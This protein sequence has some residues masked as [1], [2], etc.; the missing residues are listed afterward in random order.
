[1]KDH[2]SWVVLALLALAFFW[3]I[4]YLLEFRETVFF[5]GLVLDEANYDA[6][7]RDIAAGNIL[8]DG[9]FTSNPLAPYLI[10]LVYAVVGRDLWWLRVV[11]AGV[12]TATCYFTFRIAL[13]LFGRRSA[14]V[15]L[16]LAALYGPMIFLAGNLV[17]TVWVLAFAS[18]ALMQLTHPQPRTW[19]HVA[20][21]AAFGLATLGRPNLV[22]MLPFLPAVA[23]LRT[24]NLSLRTVARPT[25]LWAAGLA[26]VLGPVGV[27][28]AL[29]GGGLSPL[30]AHGGVNLW[31]GNNPG[32]D[33]F[34]KTPRGSGLAGGQKSLVSSSIRVAEKAVG[35][36]LTAA[37]SSAWWRQRAL[38][39]IFDHPG[40]ALGLAWR[41]L[42]YG[43]N[44]YEKPLE[45]DYYYA[46]TYSRLLR[47]PTVG[48]GLVCGF[49]LAAVWLRRQDW[50]RWA[51]LVVYAGIYLFSM[52]LTFVS[53]RYRM[54]VVVALFP[55]AGVAMTELWDQARS[56]DWRRTARSA[57]AVAVGLGVANYPLQVV[58][59]D[60][61]IA[62]THFMLGNLAQDRKDWQEALKHHREAVTLYPEWGG[63]YNNLGLA[64]LH[65]GQPEKAVETLNKAI[66]LE[67]GSRRV[68]R[69]L[70]KA[71]RALGRYEDAI[72]AFRKALEHSPRHFR[73]HLDLAA[74]LE[75]TGQIEA[76]RQAYRKALSLT[77]KEKNRKFVEQR[78]S[79]LDAAAA[80]DTNE[81]GAT[82]DSPTGDQER[83]RGADGSH[84]AGEDDARDEGAHPGQNPRRGP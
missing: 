18:F 57:A 9:P 63:Y 48:F 65:V 78:L 34:F 43:V 22:L 82:S 2:L 33:G 14:L 50:R 67:Y 20:A 30:P 54:P 56:R 72:A 69:N 25:L 83:Q 19:R 53:M 52:V 3:R 42:V 75:K 77:K 41:K 55:L 4:L 84:Q 37:E 38:R 51:L 76:A 21:G 28:N 64:Y 29:E 13:H 70:G 81:P 62:H 44:R 26:L 11:Q 47:W 46:K 79:R 80:S 61:D 68:Y 39:Y 36:R 12:D 73:T 60:H 66:A 7:A 1:M 45:T 17:A 32:A 31:I 49:A 59:I 24:M 8:G 6:W 71:Y 15:A 74:L 27:R 35:H 23:L 58:N 5:Q 40:D 16:G 10:G